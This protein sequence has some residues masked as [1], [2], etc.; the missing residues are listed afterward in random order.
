MFHTLYHLFFD[1]WLSSSAF[2]S[3]FSLMLLSFCHIHWHWAKKGSFLSSLQCRGWRTRRM[4]WGGE[5]GIWGPGW[6]LRPLNIH[7]EEERSTLPN[8]QLHHTASYRLRN[9]TARFLS[10]APPPCFPSPSPLSPLSHTHSVCNLWRLTRAGMHTH[11]QKHT[12]AHTHLR[13]HKIIPQPES[14]H[15][16]STV[17]PCL[18][19]SPSLWFDWQTLTLYHCLLLDKDSGW[20]LALTHTEKNPRSPLHRNVLPSQDLLCDSINS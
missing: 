5:G 13:N 16:P 12:H 6:G 18:L 8:F 20:I 11:W 19:C 2:F 9:H 15:T 10:C 1:S 4:W 3:I 17:S 7:A 14:L